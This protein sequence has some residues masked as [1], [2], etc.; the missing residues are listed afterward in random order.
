MGG[1][2]Y[3]YGD[4][5]TNINGNMGNDLVIGGR[6]N[7]YLMGGSEGDEVRGGNGNDFISETGRDVVFGGQGDDIVR[8]GLQTYIHGAKVLTHSSVIRVTTSC[9]VVLVLILSLEKVQILFTTSSWVST[10]SMFLVSLTVLSVHTKPAPRSRYRYGPVW[11]CDGSPTGYPVLNVDILQPLAPTGAG[12]YYKGKRDRAMPNTHQEHPEDLILTGDTWVLDAIDSAD[13]SLKIDGCPA[14]VFGTHP[15]P[16]SF[17]VH[18]VCPNKKKMESH[19]H[20]DILRYFAGKESLIRVLS[21]CLDH[22]PRVDRV[23]Q[24]DYVV[25]VVELASNARLCFRSYHC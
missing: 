25:S 13:A 11:W 2:D 17:R 6:G 19:E 8:G 14:V 22:L 1:N 24:G 4:D 3:L 18:E 12:L 9:S 20:T 5:E 23:C 10:L 7:D 16:A 15:R 21:A